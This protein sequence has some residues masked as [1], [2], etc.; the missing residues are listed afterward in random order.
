MA[1]F[2]VMRTCLLCLL[3]V[4]G[5]RAQ[6]KTR[7]VILLLEDQMLETP[8]G[9]AAFCKEHATR[10]RLELRKETVARLKKLARGHDEVLKALGS[11]PRARSL[12]IVNAIA[13][14]LT[15]AQIDQARSLKSVIFVYPAGALPPAGGDPGKV[16]EVLEAAP[17]EP[18]TTKRRQVPWNLKKLHVPE[19]WKDLKITGEGVVVAMYDAGVNYLQ[20]DLRQNVWINAGEIPNN[21]KDDDKNGYVDDYYGYD[22]RRMTAQVRPGNVHHGTWTACVVAG[23]GTGGT[24]TGVA[25]RARFMPLRAAGGPF[26]AALAFQYA[27]EQGADIVSMSFSIPNLKH[28]RGLWRRMSEHAS[29][30]GLVLVSGAGNFGVSAKI[31]VQIRVP[32]GIPCV[33]CAGGINPKKPRKVPRQLSQGP[34]EWGSVEFYGDHPMPDGLIKPD[35]CAFPGPKIALVHQTKDDYLPGSNQKF[36]NSLSAPHV[37][38]VCAL[39]LSANPDLL[40]WNVKAILEQTATDIKPKGKDTATGA[41]LVHALRAVK[42]AMK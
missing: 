28:T 21:G 29:C 33:I 12:W 41:G 34:V 20:Q 42:A 36:G 7:N 11:P 18:F 26:L 40:A 5:V 14:P 9:Y 32:E 25:P 30:C 19:V 4:G 38:G 27:I 1:E 8:H 37:A 3:I 15:L 16:A 2:R 31:P 24:I 6:D 13:V 35:V 10:K 17:R 22:F 39:M 23:D